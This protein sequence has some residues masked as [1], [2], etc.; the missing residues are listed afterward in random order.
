MVTFFPTRCASCIL[1][2]VPACNRLP[3]A[4]PPS[5]HS[6]FLSAGDPI[7]PDNTCGFVLPRD[8][9]LPYDPVYEDYLERRR[10]GGG[11]TGGE[12]KLT[13]EWRD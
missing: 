4:T 1:M 13:G 8:V 6:N 3:T 2:P 5:P 7:M 9:P 10:R 12:H 11:V